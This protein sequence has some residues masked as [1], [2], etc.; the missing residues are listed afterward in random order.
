MINIAIL[1]YGNLGKGVEKA[2]MRSKDCR[3]FGV[4]TRRDHK[5]LQTIS[6]VPTYAASDLFTIDEKAV[7]VVMLCVGS[8]D[9]FELTPKIL[10]RFCTVDGFDMHAKIPVYCKTMDENAKRYQKTAFVAGGWD[11]GLFSAERLLMETAL[12]SGKTYTFWGKGVSQ[13]HTQ[14]IKRVDG[15]LDGVQYTL[16]NEN[17]V[18]RIE[19]GE[20]PDLTPFDMHK[21]ECYVAAE[22][23]ANKEKI[24]RDIQNMPDYFQGYTTSVQFVDEQ[25]LKEKHREFPHGGKVI[26]VGKTGTGKGHTA[27]FSLSLSSNPEFTGGVLLSCARAVVRLRK[28]KNYGAKTVFDVPFTYFSEKPREELIKTFL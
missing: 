14:A 7:D 5:R 27:C 20:T 26:R 12:P 17:V 28:E 15:V 23:G 19:R 16:P 3:L 18:E 2:V 6:G 11:P 24:K 1:G 21:R 22:K 8:L 25:T 9:L 13:G 4:F 10:Q